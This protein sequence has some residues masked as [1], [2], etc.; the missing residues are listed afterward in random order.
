MKQQFKYSDA[1]IWLLHISSSILSNLASLH[2]SLISILETMWTFFLVRQR[3]KWHY[4]NSS[5]LSESGN[6]S[7]YLWEQW[8]QKVELEYLLSLLWIILTSNWA[9][10]R[11]QASPKKRQ[12]SL[13]LVVSFLRRSSN[14]V[15]LLKLII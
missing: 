7:H 1:K 9:K 3:K 13:F 5:L 14:S 11:D 4:G 6:F 15:I 8:S 2:L 10:C 12:P